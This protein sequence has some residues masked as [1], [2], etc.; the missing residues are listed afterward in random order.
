MGDK[1]VENNGNAVVEAKMLRR[2]GFKSKR[3]PDPKRDP[4]RVRATPTVTPGAYRVAQAVQASA[5]VPKSPPARD[6]DYLRRVAQLPCCNCG[7]SGYSQAAHS[8]QGKGMAMKASDHD[9]FPLCCA[10]PGVIGCHIGLDQGAMFDKET[11]RAKEAEWVAQ[12][13]EVLGHSDD[14]GE[15]A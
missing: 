9:T 11:R 4:D 12:T 7:V 2:T 6:K 13:R 15:K 10:R 14:K 3:L 5:P 1:A 8:N